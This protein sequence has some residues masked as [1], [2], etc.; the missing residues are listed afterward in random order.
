MGACCANKTKK[1][2]GTNEDE[3]FENKEVDVI[4]LYKDNKGYRDNVIRIQ[5]TIRGYNARNQAR[6]K[7]IDANSR[8]LRQISNDIETGYDTKNPIVKVT[9]IIKSKL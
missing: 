5:S 4:E 3:E 6:Q 2:G 7:F 9:E 1:A 8:T